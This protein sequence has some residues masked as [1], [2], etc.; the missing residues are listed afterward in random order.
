MAKEKEWA[1]KIAVRKA[2]EAMV[3][4]TTAKDRAEDTKVAKKSTWSED[5]GGCGSC[6]P[7]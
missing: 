7:K 2:V 5:N 3:A 6:V 1:P 4:K